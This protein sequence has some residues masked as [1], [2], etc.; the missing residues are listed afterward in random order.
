MMTTRGESLQ[1]KIKKETSDLYRVLEELEE[2]FEDFRNTLSSVPEEIIN[3][4][5][6]LEEFISS[7]K[8]FATRVATNSIQAKAVFESFSDRILKHVQSLEDDIE[9]YQNLYLQT[10]GNLSIVRAVREKQVSDANFTR[11]T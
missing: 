3:N 9:K 6:R 5:H 7:F 10:Q 4:P 2:S 11:S 1:D 8:D